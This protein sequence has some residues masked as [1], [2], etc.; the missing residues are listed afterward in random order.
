MNNF[1]RS[2]LLD[3]IKANQFAAMFRF[4]INLLISILLVRFHY[5]N[6]EVGSFEYYILFASTFGFFW[7]HAYAAAILSKV[8]KMA[9]TQ[10]L[11]ELR[12]IIHQLTLIGITMAVLAYFTLNS[13]LMPD[14]S[15]WAL[16]LKISVCL[17]VFFFIASPIPENYFLLMKW[18]KKIISYQ[19]FLSSLQ[20]LVVIVALVSHWKIESLMICYFA[21]YGIRFLF[22]IFLTK[23]NWKIDW[24]KQKSWLLFSIPLVLHFILGSGMD[25]LD[26]HLVSYFF[27]EE[28]FL[29]YKYGA[30]EL[31]FSLLLINAMSAA[32]IGILAK[33]LAQ[34]S[35]LR[36]KVNK[37]MNLL[38]PLSMV[39]MFASPF[40]FKLAYGDE[41]LLSAVVFNIYLLI[42]SSRILVP[43]VIMYAKE[44]NKS[45]MYFSGLELIVNVILSLILL[46]YMGVA[47]VAIATV[48]AFLL[49]RIFSVL[50][51]RIKYG[52]PLDSYIDIRRYASFLSLLVACFF[53]SYFIFFR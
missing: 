9:E 41:F 46:K 10:Y 26:G 24:I 47:G 12:H 50:Y 52:I 20:L 21:I 16:S 2:I 53:T 34:I 49:N 28:Q 6:E 14:T 30:R 45:L 35:I 25:Y 22:G 43:Q 5:T 27:D 33:D 17:F 15:S 13:G 51:C 4:G 42:V 1:F 18:P 38:F 3:H 7:V 32:M 37:L 44:D 29:F 8:A 39:L 40:I 11:S 36:L 23:A 19:V 48:F 31:P